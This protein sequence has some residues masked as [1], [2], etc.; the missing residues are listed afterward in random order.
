M[1]VYRTRQYLQSRD[2]NDACDAIHAG[3]RLPIKHKQNR[4]T[5]HP[6]V[7]RMH[8]VVSFLLL[9]RYV[10]NVAKRGIW[11]QFNE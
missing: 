10:P 2:R 3:R 5:V 9:A 8:T 1:A 11:H 7:D 4:S 6:R